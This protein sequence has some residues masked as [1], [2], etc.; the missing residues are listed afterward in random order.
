MI[1]ICLSFTVS[2]WEQERCKSTVYQGLG[3]QAIK[4]SKSSSQQQFQFQNTGTTGQPAHRLAFWCQATHFSAHHPHEQAV[5][6]CQAGLCWE[7]VCKFKLSGFS[8]E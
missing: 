7:L 5:T 6:E 3:S 8:N 4:S 2:L 1:P